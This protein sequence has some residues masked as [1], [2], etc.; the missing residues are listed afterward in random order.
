VDAPPA[1]ATAGGEARAT[2]EPSEPTTRGPGVDVRT[3]PLTGGRAARGEPSEPAKR[4]LALPLAAPATAL[5]PGERGR[6][7]P[8]TIPLMA[9]RGDAGPTMTPDVEVESHRA[10]SED[11]ALEPGTLVVGAPPST[12]TRPAARAEPARRQ[13]G[14]GGDGKR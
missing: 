8:N 5:P 7:P 12:Q 10:E 4:P 14:D 9:D 2:A 6:R 11:G 1:T 3:V 13:I